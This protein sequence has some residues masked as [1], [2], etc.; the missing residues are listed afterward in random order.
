M[1]TARM[2]QD[3]V[4]EEE[5]E[6]TEVSIQSKAGTKEKRSADG[7]NYH[8]QNTLIINNLLVFNYYY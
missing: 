5:G 6:K 2:K 7:L 4:T 1:G 8:N 3:K